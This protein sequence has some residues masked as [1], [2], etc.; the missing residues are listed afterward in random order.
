M[1]RGA[2]LWLHRFIRHWATAETK[3]QPFIHPTAMIMP[4]VQVAPGVEVG[5]Y[6]YIRSGAKLDSGRIGSFCSIAPGVMIG[7]DEH[8]LDA[9]STH[10]FWYAPGGLTLPDESPR[11]SGK[12]M[13][14]QQ[15]AAPII[16]HDVWVGAGAVIL[17]GAVIENGAVIGACAVVKG[18]IPAYGIAVGMPAKVVRY[19]FS[20]D[21]R[22]S[23]EA[24]GWWDW[25]E[26]EIRRMKPLFRDVDMFLDELEREALRA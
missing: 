4:E 22:A 1:K 12:P 6:S 8:P 18:R 20:P 17:R 19:R 13:W 7:G 3:R 5:R 24:S 10:P 9:V 25:E 21:I 15:S 23:L 2:A 16:G 11:R 26:A 14:E